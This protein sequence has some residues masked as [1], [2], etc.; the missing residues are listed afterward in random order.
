MRKFLLWIVISVFLTLPAQAG[1]LLV[2][3]FSGSIGG[4]EFDNI[5]INGQT[6]TISITRQPNAQSFI[7][8]V[9]GTTVASD[10]VAVEG[11]LTLLVTST[12]VPG[13]YNLALS[14]STATEII[15]GFKGAQAIMQF[16]QESGVAPLLLP[17]FFNMT[18]HVTSLTENNDPTYDFSNFSRGDGTI[19]FAITATTFTDATS[20]ATLFTTVGATAVGSGSFSQ[21]VL[22]PSSAFLLGIGLIG[23][24]LRLRK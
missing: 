21:A 2:N 13:A 5:G 14:P 3:T 19:N 4:I 10:P 20:F 17:A 1:S 18:G 9:N 16:N 11:P 8:N 23:L 6:A 24:F 7:N 15:G 12:A 22:E